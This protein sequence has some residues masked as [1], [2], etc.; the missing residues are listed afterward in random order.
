MRYLLLLV[1]TV[2]FLGACGGEGS[3]GE[4]LSTK[5]RPSN[6]FALADAP[7]PPQKKQ[8]ELAP[9]ADASTTVASVD[10]Q[11]SAVVQEEAEE[12]EA[13]KP[14]RKPLAPAKAQFASQ[15]HNYGNITE[16]DIIEHIFVLE[17]T[18]QRPLEILKT[19]G[20]CGCTVASYSFL[21]I[22]PG[23]KSKIKA[24]FNS[25]GK[26]GKQKTTLTVTTNG[27]PR[28]YILSLEGSVRPGDKNA[29]SKDSTN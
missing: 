5:P 8:A 22:K 19:S 6:P 18:G 12:V 21:P 29:S 26:L 11:A 24:R 20:S 2:A 25:L 3:N 28:T 27:Q 10:T 4:S 1:M 17:N 14:K 15:T 23:E 9:P 16:G 13:P 7:V